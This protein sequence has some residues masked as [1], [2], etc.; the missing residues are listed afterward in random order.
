MP[1][2]EIAAIGR[3]EFFNRIASGAKR[4]ANWKRDNSIYDA[5]RRYA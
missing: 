3:R 2:V 1:S 4:S 5:G